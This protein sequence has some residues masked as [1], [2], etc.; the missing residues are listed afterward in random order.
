MWISL[1]EK[2]GSTI[3]RPGVYSS[4]QHTATHCNTLQH[5]ATHCN[6]H[7]NNSLSLWKKP[8]AIVERI[9]V[10]AS[11]QHTATHCQTLQHT[12]THGTTHN[13]NSLSF[14]R[15][16]PGSVQ[17]LWLLLSLQCI[18]THCNTLQHTGTHCNTLQ[19]RRSTAP[20]HITLQH[21][22][23]HCNTA[24]QWS[25]RKISRFS[26]STK[27]SLSHAYTSTPLYFGPSSKR[28]HWRNLCYISPIY[29]QASVPSRRVNREISRFHGPQLQSI[30]ASRFV[31]QI[32][33][34]IQFIFRRVYREKTGCLPNAIQIGCTSECNCY[35]N[36]L[37]HA[38]QSPGPKSQL[39]TI[40]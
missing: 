15:K 32:I 19:H 7:N 3:K 5:A 4:L 29:E 38:V 36:T 23:T 35:C 16:A 12:A 11:L 13:Q 34:V 40:M 27:K 20:H 39:C 28:V 31:M 8:Q 37:Q 10:F 2:T 6:T 18:A 17:R 21:T 25:R 1:K 24:P 33:A 9:G 22:T 30:S 14:K 26:L